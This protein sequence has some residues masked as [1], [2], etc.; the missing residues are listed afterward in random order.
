MTHGLSCSAACGNLLD[1]GSNPCPL[2]WQADSQPLRH[3]G[4][5]SPW[6]LTMKHHC[7]LGAVTMGSPQGHPAFAKPADRSALGGSPFK[8]EEGEW[9]EMLKRREVT[10]GLCTVPRNSQRRGLR[11]L[12]RRLSIG[13]SFPSYSS[14][15]LLSSLTFLLPVVGTLAPLMT[16]RHCL[17]LQKLLRAEEIPRSWCQA[18][19]R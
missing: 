13:T 18:D 2:H 17:G 15:W 1:Q 19:G 8:P 10:L 11:L 6:L 12:L 14:S 4:S 5:P 9:E 3:Q 16:L 7:G